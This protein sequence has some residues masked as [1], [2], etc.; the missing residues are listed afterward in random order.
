MTK[1]G[2]RATPS[3]LGG[4]LAEDDLPFAQFW[5][6]ALQVN[7]SGYAEAY[8]GKDHGLSPDAYLSALL[9]ECQEQ[10]IRLIGLADHGSVSDVDAIRAFLLPQG[11]VVLPGFEI[12]TT[13]KIQWVCLF[14]EDTRVDQLTR[15]LG[16]LGLL[17]PKDGVR[18]T[19]LSGDQL[20]AEVEALGGFC[21]AA[22][23]TDP[24]GI[25]T[26][27]ANH[28]WVDPRLRA[29]Q[30]RETPAK[31][32]QP[33]RQILANTDP[34]YRRDRP[35]ALINATDIEEP[36][37]LRDSRASCFI[38]MTRPGFQSLCTAFMDPESRIR[39]VDDMKED[40]YSCI[41]RL[42]ID[43]G[44]LDGVDIRFS[45][46]LNTIIGGRGTGKSTLIECVRYVLGLEHKT[47]DAKKQGDAIV[48]ENLGKDAGR[49]EITLVSSRQQGLRYRVIRRYGEPLRVIGP[50]DNE[51]SLTVDDLLPGI[52]IYGQNGIYE[53]A[54]DPN[55][56]VRVLDR[57][58]PN[59][60]EHEARLAAIHKKL[61]A[62]AEKL[63]R[64][65]DQLEEL[66]EQLQK[67]P[68]LEEQTKQFDA[69]GF[70]KKLEQI[71][72]L[73]KEGQLPL[74]IAEEIERL[75]AG[76][77]AL[78]DSLPDTTFLSDKAIE[79]L[80]HADILGRGRA[81]LDRVRSSIKRYV[82]NAEKELTTASADVKMI[83]E[84][85]THARR[86]AEKALEKEFDALPAVAGKRGAEVARTYQALQKQIASIRPQQAKIG[87]VTALANTLRQERRNLL[88]E[89][90]DVR[91][92]RTRALE[93]E[94]KT[95]N[96]KLAG[97]LRLNVQPNGNRE[98]LKTFLSGLQGIGPKSIGWVDQAGDLTIPALVEACRAGPP[99]LLGKKWGVSAAKAE[100]IC[101]LA[102][103][104]LLALE[105]VDLDD[106]VALELNVAHDGETF[107]PLER[108]STGQQ[109]T[110]ILHLLLLDNTDP[111]IMDQPEDN[112]DNA[113]IA[114]RI[115]QELRTAKTSRQ[116]LFAT[117]NAN[118]PVF[119]DAEW[120]GVFT[121]T[122]DRGSVPPENQG[123]IDVPHIRDEAAR[124]LDGGREAF[125]QRQQKYGY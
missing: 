64:A 39:L 22:H 27:K 11:I 26:Q 17:D 12:C 62:S 79:R 13:E 23:A 53:L 70:S 67:L 36:E 68:G 71:P 29:A 87:T 77:V 46:H 38:K 106:R 80:P 48:K 101:K 118:I 37:R 94:V 28:L 81:V 41:E 42:Q 93:Q 10:G 40:F 15:Y 108:L 119:G 91:N 3:S 90:S 123:S 2:A 85:L 110:A 76:L 84:E 109:C 43:G 114:D 112:L 30:I 16:K 25:L 45:P 58:L 65:E 74:R 35:M 33:Y 120:I 20:L 115:V 113:F 1:A 44:Y 66:T 60:S 95:L 9:K 51:S 100:A 82:A 96:K 14:P 4:R 99:A 102:R 125:L 19:K 57:F 7:S 32:P 34:N 24:K 52:E 92:G 89:L 73:E 5:K 56:L 122:E 124:I 47:P 88:G 97:K 50:D 121:A 21:Y 107:R 116:F 63:S 69:I 18:P 54:R 83:L 49:I 31:A 61:K 103:A 75:E 78:K 98:Q 117:H 86:A 6:C 8:R 55:A 104:D 59:R 111:L 105:T 72:L